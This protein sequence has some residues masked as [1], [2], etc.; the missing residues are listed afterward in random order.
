VF[1][2]PDFLLPK[3]R[4]HRAQISR[5]RQLDWTGEGEDT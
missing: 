1:A 4:K 3:A 2:E 5:K